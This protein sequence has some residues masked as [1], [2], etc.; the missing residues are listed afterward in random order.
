MAVFVPAPAGQYG[1]DRQ[2][3][4]TEV[5][6]KSGETLV[7][8]GLVTKQESMV[9]G[10]VPGLRRI[11]LLGKLFQSEVREE[12]YIETVIY[13]TPYIN[14]P[15]AFSLRISVRTSKSISARSNSAGGMS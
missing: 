4:Q 13:V 3:V 9:E 15:S 6:V 7:I 8:G 10:G 11:P 2:I 12:K 1:I 14:E 5:L